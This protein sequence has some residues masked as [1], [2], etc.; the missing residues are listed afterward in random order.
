MLPTRHKKIIAQNAFKPRPKIKILYVPADKIL[1]GRDAR[2]VHHKMHVHLASHLGQKL[3]NVAAHKPALSIVA[4]AGLKKAVAE[5]QPG[6]NGL[7]QLPW[8]PVVWVQWRAVGQHGI[9]GGKQLG[10]R[11]V[12]IPAHKLADRTRNKNPVFQVSFDVPDEF[13]HWLRHRL[14]S[15]HCSKHW[16]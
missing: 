8:P 5:M 2:V 6:Q 7:A 1:P 13:R 4:S 3:D 9:D 15:S 14:G 16:K 12:A 10:Q 11:H